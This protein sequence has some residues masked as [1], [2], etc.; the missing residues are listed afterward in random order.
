MSFHTLYARSL[1]RYLILSEFFFF[2]F[3]FHSNF[4]SG[5]LYALTSCKY[6][7]F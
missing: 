5:L 2:I 7:D 6:L 1:S 4:P 3:S